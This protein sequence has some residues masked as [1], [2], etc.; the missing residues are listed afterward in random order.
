MPHRRSGGLFGWEA[1]HCPE[2][3]ISL[4]TGEDRKWA[5]SVL[6]SAA[7][8]KNS[9]TKKPNDFTEWLP[10]RWTYPIIIHQLTD[11]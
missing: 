9:C 2:S 4:A 8:A 7:I 1:D 6:T 3:A 11:L 10:N 5:C